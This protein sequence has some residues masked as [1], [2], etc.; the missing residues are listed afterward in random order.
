MCEI[1]CINSASGTQVAVVSVGK[2]VFFLQKARH[3]IH[4]Q[5]GIGKLFKFGTSLE[6]PFFIPFSENARL[7]GIVRADQIGLRVVPL[8]RVWLGHQPL[9][10]LKSLIL[11][12]IS[13]SL[14][15]FEKNA[16]KKSSTCR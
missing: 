10:V 4:Y 13:N 9:Y 15:W 5:Y 6:K 11:M 3:F 12:L 16:H 7:K 1:I 2:T 14:N 8:Q